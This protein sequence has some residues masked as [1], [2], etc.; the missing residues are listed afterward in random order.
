MT[1]NGVGSGRPYVYSND[2]PGFIVGCLPTTPGPRTS[3]MWP[4]P[5]VMT[6]CRVRS[7]TVSG[8]SLAMV[9]VY[10]KNH[11]FFDGADWSA[12]YSDCTLTRTP[13]VTASEMNMG[14]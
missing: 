10:R 3:S 5:S 13:R 11:W 12:E 9:T 8:P 6:Q 14:S 1:P 4:V 2:S 7:W